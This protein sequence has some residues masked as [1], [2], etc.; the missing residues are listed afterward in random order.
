[1]FGRPRWR[2]R[3]RL[4]QLS[5][6]ARA[7]LWVCVLGVGLSAELATPL[8]AAARRE[9]TFNYPYSRV[10]T[11]AVRLMRV[12][13][14]CTITEKDRDDGYLL[15]E[16]PDRGKTYPGSVELVLVKVNDSEA[17]RVVLQIPALPSYVENMIVDRLARKL[18]QEF[19]PPKE[20]KRPVEPPSSDKDDSDQASDTDKPKPPATK[21][22]PNGDKP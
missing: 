7:A 14:G 12:D 13:F 8:T 21:A 6:T 3:A 19:G 15:F 9:S 5:Q 10:W 4:S 17:T 22:K 16:Y 2:K 18:E 1:M 20:V 11:S